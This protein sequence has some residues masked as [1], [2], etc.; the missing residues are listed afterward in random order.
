MTPQ[1][2]LIQKGVGAQQLLFQSCTAFGMHLVTMPDTDLLA[3]T[4]NASLRTRLAVQQTYNLHESL[5]GQVW[6]AFKLEDESPALAAVLSEIEALTAIIADLVIQPWLTGQK[7][8]AA[9]RG[10]VVGL[11]SP[12]TYRALRLHGRLSPEQAI[13][14]T[15]DAL[16]SRLST[17]AAHT[18]GGC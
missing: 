7:R 8:S 17:V 10:F 6:G 11:L 3:C 4:K 15:N 18:K 5:F 12:L 16:V 13:D 9:V 14:S 2:P 1:Q